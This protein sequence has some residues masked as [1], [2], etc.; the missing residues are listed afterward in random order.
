MFRTR[1]RGPY[2]ITKRLSDLNYQIQIT[3]GKLAI[4]NINRLKRCHDAP[5]RKKAKK[6]TAPTIKEN[7]TEEEWDSSDEEPLFLLGKCKLIPTSQSL[8]NSKRLEEVVTNNPTRND[9][10]ERDNDNRQEEVGDN[11]P[12]ETQDITEPQNEQTL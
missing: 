2:L 1:W 10:V 4:V 9:T 3:P 7:T 5:K 8:D 12:D 11:P 6:A